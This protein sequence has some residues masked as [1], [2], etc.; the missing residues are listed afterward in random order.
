MT[1]FVEDAPPGVDRVR[2]TAIVVAAKYL[3]TLS[4]AIAQGREN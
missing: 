1:G 3:E 4:R 2:A